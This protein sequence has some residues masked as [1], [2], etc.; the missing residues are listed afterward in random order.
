LHNLIYFSIFY[1]TKLQAIHDQI[2]IEIKETCINYEY[3][4]IKMGPMNDKPQHFIFFSLGEKSRRKKKTLEREIFE[5][6][7]G[8]GLDVVYEFL[9]NPMLFLF[10]LL[11]GV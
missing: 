7:N 4:E 8:E 1:S 2:D 3:W 11:C 10:M 5:G 9:S 6:V